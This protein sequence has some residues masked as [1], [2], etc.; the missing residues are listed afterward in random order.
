MTG[1][2]R[3][4]ARIA[5]KRRALDADYFQAVHAARNAG[6]TLQQIA[7]AAGLANRSGARYLL[8]RTSTPRR[9]EP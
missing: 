5:A 2:L 3:T 6:A 9:D 1:Q 7:D 4:L 8:T